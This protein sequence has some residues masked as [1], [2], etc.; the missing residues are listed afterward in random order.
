MLFFKMLLYFQIE[1]QFTYSAVLVSGVWQGDSVV[2]LYAYIQTLFPY[3][4]L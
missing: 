2:C 3:T 4:L 1:I